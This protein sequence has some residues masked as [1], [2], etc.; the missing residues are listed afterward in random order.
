MWNS[1]FSHKS[2]LEKFLWFLPVL[3]LLLSF[4]TALA[5]VLKGPGAINNYHIYTGVFRHLM[6]E[7]NLY[8]SY[9][10][11]YFDRNLY[12]P[13]FAFLI[14]PFA[15]LKTGLGCVLWC[16]ANTLVL[17]YA[18][19]RL[20]FD[21]KK[22]SIIAAIV[23]IENLTSLHNVEFNTML[24]GW[25]LL[26]FVLVRKEKIF[27]ACFFIM[28]GFL[29]KVYS[30]VG[31]AFFF[32]TPHKIKFAGYCVL[33]MLVLL[34]FPMLFASPH[35]V[36]S[37]YQEWAR[38]L[39]VKNDLNLVSDMQDISVM[40]MCRRIL[41]WQNISALLFLLPAVLVT[42]IPVLIPNNWKK[43]EFQLLYLSQIL[44]GLVVFSSSSE[45][46]TYVIAVTGVAIWFISQR[47]G[48][49]PLPQVLLGLVF[50]L[51]ILSPTDLFPSY[52]SKTIVD[53]YAL[54]AL[55]C[56]LVWVVCTVQLYF[57]RL[58]SGQEGN[59]PYSDP[60]GQCN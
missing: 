41:G 13:F 38:A 48:M 10:A 5:E 21:R 57:P 14:A 34:L 33:W 37:M 6:A 19:Y 26:S 42:L 30:I 3:W 56:F 7:K 22:K 39:M 45:S 2:L 24:T 52:I 58:R 60:E 11:E 51:T 18:I 27:W 32:F 40:G 49:R 50:L 12:G 36:L 16:M 46:P 1:S 31:L 4:L 35:Y 23:L 54:K 29:I 8:L 59:T 47:T 9:P 55:P 17:L 28:A 15:L 43:S 53:P 44:I 25:V 20:P